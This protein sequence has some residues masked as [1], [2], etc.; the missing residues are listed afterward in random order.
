MLVREKKIWTPDNSFLLEYRARAE[1]GEIIIGQ[2]LWQEL[3][4]LAEDFRKE[5]YFY[6]TDAAR[7]RMDFMENCVRLTKSPFYN[8][9]MVLMLWQ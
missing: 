2:D 9:P 4:N 6:D 1:N 3:D 5:R 7:L 8:K